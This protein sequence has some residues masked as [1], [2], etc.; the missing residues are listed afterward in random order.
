[1]SQNNCHQLGAALVYEVD[2]LRLKLDK[3]CVA[4]AI[5]LLDQTK[6]FDMVNHRILLQKLQTLFDISN[7]ACSLIRSYLVNRSQ[8]IYLNGNISNCLDVGRGFHQWPI[9][10]PLL[11]CIYI[12]NL[13]DVLV[14]C[15]VLMYT[16]DVQLYR[17]TCIE[18]INLFIDI[19]TKNWPRLM[20]FV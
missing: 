6:A 14:N 3:N 18:N 8:R 1:M 2:D 13:P 11:F 10:G 19:I 9:S 5:V 16:D 15:N 20:D 17:S 4:L 12:N 7:S